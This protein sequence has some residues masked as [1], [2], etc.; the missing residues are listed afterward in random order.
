MRELQR[1]AEEVPDDVAVADEDVDLV[2][3]VLGVAATDVATETGLDATA[4]LV[5]VL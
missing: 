5:K 2:G 3:L 1:P 4:L